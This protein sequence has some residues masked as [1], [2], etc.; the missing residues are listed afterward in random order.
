MCSLT[1]YGILSSA[2]CTDT[3]PY[4][5]LHG[6][7][8]SFSFISFCRPGI[9]DPDVPT[10]NEVRSSRTGTRALGFH[11]EARHHCHLLAC[12]PPAEYS[13]LSF[14]IASATLAFPVHPTEVSSS[15]LL[16]FPLTCFIFFTSSPLLFDVIFVVFKSV[17]Y[18]LC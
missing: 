15:T 12:L 13:A 10:M 14:N 3:L 4:I 2:T 16:S 1:F 5:N 11:T 6:P 9:G 18:S 8:H 17:S 7:L